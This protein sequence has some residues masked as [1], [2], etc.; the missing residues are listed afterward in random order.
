MSARVVI[1]VGACDELGRA[2]DPAVAR[3]VVEQI[4]AR[5]GPPEV[6][7]NVIGTYHPGECSTWSCVRWGFG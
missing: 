2:T 4:A 6:L 7:V 1:V 5:V 3:S